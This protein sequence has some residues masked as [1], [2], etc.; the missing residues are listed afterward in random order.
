MCQYV[1][2]TWKLS[3]IAW[4]VFDVSESIRVANNRVSL[5]L[6][7]RLR[8]FRYIS[9]FEFLFPRLADESG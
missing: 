6:N 2:G 8:G 3:F 1:V 9:T 4:C 7:F 5:N